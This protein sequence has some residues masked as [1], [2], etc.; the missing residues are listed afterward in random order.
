MYAECDREILKKISEMEFD[1]QSRSNSLQV[2]RPALLPYR[3][4]THRL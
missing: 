4:Q 3:N 2:K 1:K